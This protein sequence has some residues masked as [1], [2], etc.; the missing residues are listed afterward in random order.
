MS[1][2]ASPSPGWEACRGAWKPRP[3]CATFWRR[4]TCRWVGSADSRAW[5]SRPR[6]VSAAASASYSDRAL[7]IALRIDAHQHFTPEYS[8]ELLYPI[9][10]R[11]RFDA[12]V[13][14]SNVGL[15]ACV[16][17]SRHD[18]I[19]AVIVEADLSS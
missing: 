2:C 1:W 3:T 18:F 10:K 8:P 19:R 14:V 6:E 16:L 11:N 4:A 13:L 12:T 9:L 17:A 15:Q 5:W 7:R